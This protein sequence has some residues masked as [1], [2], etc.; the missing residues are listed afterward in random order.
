MLTPDQI[1]KRKAGIGSSDIAAVAGLNPWRKPIDVF[2]EKTGRATG[3]STI[4]TRVGDTVEGAIATLYQQDRP[5][6]FLAMPEPTVTRE[7]WEIAT[8]DRIAVVTPTPGESVDLLHKRVVEIKMVGARVAHHWTEDSPP[9]YVLAQVLWQLHVLKLERGDI[10]A[11][12][13]GTDFRIYDVA[14]AKEV[15]EALAEIARAFWHDNVL[16]DVPPAVDHSDSWKRYVAERW[17]TAKNE[18]VEAPAE[19]EAVA[20]RLLAAKAALSESEQRYDQ[21][22][23]EMKAMLE[24]RAGFRGFGWSCT[25]KNTANGA[26]DYKALCYALGATEEQIE[27]YRRPGAR[28]FM[29]TP[30]KES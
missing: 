27:S 10:A 30:S 23:N 2:L 14:F 11:L 6:T 8:P 3:A 15:A 20:R 26:P 13:G 21:A 24:D 9:D 22:A 16:K 12:V 28:R 17:P 29:F 7:P 18:V 5:C 25:W 4:Q 19:A 1:K